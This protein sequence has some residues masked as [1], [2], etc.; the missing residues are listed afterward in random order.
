MKSLRITAMECQSWHWGKYGALQP[1]FYF[2][3]ES[4]CKR[5][6]NFQYF[7]LWTRRWLNTVSPHPVSHSINDFEHQ[8]TLCQNSSYLLENCLKFILNSITKWK[9]IL[10]RDGEWKK[11]EVNKIEKNKFIFYLFA[12]CF[13]TLTAIKFNLLQKQKST[14]PIIFNSFE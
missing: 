13:S 5:N 6:I 9:W 2:T 12:P 11:E 10:S 3:D 4:K 14:K 8:I 7:W 1:N